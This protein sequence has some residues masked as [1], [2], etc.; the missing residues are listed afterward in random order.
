MPP[1]LKK[2]P[3]NVPAEPPS[4][5]SRCRSSDESGI[6]DSVLPDP[7]AVSAHAP[8][9]VMLIF[10]APVRSPPASAR[11]SDARPVRSP[12]KVLAAQ[13]PSASLATAD[14]VVTTLF[15]ST[16]VTMFVSYD[17]GVVEVLI[18]VSN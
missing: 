2:M 4:V 16:S 6:Y 3:A 7:P 1:A 11:F 17:S 13:S 15:P 10:R 18:P 5:F 9:L 8:P 14:H 12:M